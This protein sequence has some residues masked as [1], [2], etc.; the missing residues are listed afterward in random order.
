MD[1]FAYLMPIVD[2]LVINWIYYKI[3]IA[4]C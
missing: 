3:R 2:I 4:R 1:F